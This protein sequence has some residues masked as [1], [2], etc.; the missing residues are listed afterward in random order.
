MKCYNN[1]YENIISPESLFLAWIAFTVVSKESGMFRNLE[2]ELEQ[3]IFQLHRE[4]RRRTYRHGSY[5]SFY[6]Q[7]PK[8]RHIHKAAVRDRVLHHAVFRC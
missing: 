3:N 6:I 8:Q 2:W 7:D 1:I 4:L 5:V